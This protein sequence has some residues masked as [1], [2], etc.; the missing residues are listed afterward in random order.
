MAESARILVV[1]DE[2]IVAQALRRCLQSLGYD[3]VALA[4]TGEDALIKVEQ[5]K[6]DL[7]LLDI[8]LEGKMDGIESAS[9]I[10]KQFGIPVVYLTAYSNPE[11]LERAKV[12]EPYG[13]V[14]K[15]YEDRE[16]QVVLE[17]ALYKHRMERKLEA[18]E[19]WFAATLKSIGDGVVATDDQRRITFMNTIAEQLT[20]WRLEEA[21]GSALSDVFKLIHEETRQPAEAPLRKAIEQNRA[22]PMANH[23]M[24]VAKDGSERPVE[25]CATPIA[26]DNGAAL[27]GVMVFRDVT[28]RKQAQAASLK[29]AAIVNNSHDAII[30]ESLEGT[31]TSWNGGAERLFG[32]AAQEILGSP[33]SRLFPPERSQE[34]QTIAMRVK[35]GDH[36]PAHETVRRR[37]DGKDVDVMLSTSPIKNAEGAVVGAASIVQDLAHVKKLEQQY[38]QAQK[39]EAIGRLAGGVAHDFNNLL[40]VIIGYCQILLRGSPDAE[41]VREFVEQIA[42]AGEKA[43]DLTQQ[44]LVYSRKQIRQPKVV[45]LNDVLQSSVKM[46]RRLIGEDLELA[47]SPGTGL[48]HVRA[49][50]SQMEQIIMNLAVNARD[51]MTTG[52]KLT[53]QTSTAQI[54]GGAESDPF[55]IPPGTYVLLQVSDTGCG[56]D[57]E[58]QAHIFEPFF[59]TKAIGKGTGLG[60]ATVYGIVKQCGGYI[61]VDSKLGQGTSFA[62]HLPSV[63]LASL[64][65]ELSQ[66][67]PQAPLG[68]ETILLVEDEDAV[69]ALSHLMLRQCGYKVLV[70]SNGK[71]ALE[72]AASYEGSIDLLLT[73]VVMPI[74]GGRLLAESLKQTRENIRVLYLSG[75]EDDAV[76]SGT[77][78]PKV[79]FLTK[80]FTISIL[81][82]KVR[83]VLNKSS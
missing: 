60:L 47:V 38:L 44:L 31:I 56:M 49:D 52:G 61:K 6:P 45:D 30:G 2:R 55:E 63:E 57:E 67:Q 66:D 59:T 68:S 71:E 74:L 82:Q 21:K 76:S 70:A 50:P 15:P 73:D 42:K 43:A 77:F 24:L 5:L 22:V 69:R 13:Y 64:Q 46:L 75:Y 37:N 33:S 39:M 78:G 10:R 18:R 25:D 41:K 36:V 40:T 27:G 35:A 80:P 54:T 28:E 14:L 12:T 17:I 34:I 62:I 29:L 51:A 20:G 32:Y 48:H 72:L 58:T 7:V 53:I 83:E 65:G 16:L 9:R 81:A 1:E 8:Q 23:M 3:V 4:T 79:E 26:D 19:R 11:V